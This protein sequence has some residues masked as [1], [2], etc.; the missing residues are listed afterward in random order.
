MPPPLLPNLLLPNL[1]KQSSVTADRF[2][3]TSPAVT[4]L[5]LGSFKKRRQKQRQR[6]MI[7]RRM[8]N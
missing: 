5:A 7:K 4:V 3:L 6:N 2:E 1:Q 8:T